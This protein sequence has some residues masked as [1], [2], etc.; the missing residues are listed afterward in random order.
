VKGA[1]KGSTFGP[2]VLRLR[3]YFTKQLGFV[4]KSE[5]EEN[6]LVFEFSE[7]NS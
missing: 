1:P 3:K 2:E 5:H 7:I 6:I 4:N